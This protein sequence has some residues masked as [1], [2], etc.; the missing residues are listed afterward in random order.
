MAGQTPSRPLGRREAAVI[1][2]GAPIPAGCDAVVMHRAD[3][4][5]EG[6][7]RIDE[8][9]GPR[10]AEHPAPRARDAGRRAWSWPRARC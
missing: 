10:R 7:V 1:M 3:P 8:P 2:T 5:D 6:R 4:A 9:G